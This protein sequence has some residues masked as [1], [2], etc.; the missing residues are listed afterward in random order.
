ETVEIMEFVDPK[1]INPLL[2]YKPYY[3]EP[4]K[5]GGKAY[6]LLRDTLLQTATVGISKVVIKTRQ[7]LAALKP[8]QKALALELMRFPEELINASELDIPERTEPG[9]HELAI[10]KDLVERMT[11]RWDPARYKDDYRSALQKLIQQRV[12]D[13]DK[14]T[15]VSSKHSRQPTGVIDLVEILKNSLAQVDRK[16]AKSA[17]AR[18]IP[19][20]RKAA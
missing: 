6:V 15:Q 17:R 1:E 14:P 16:P 20:G 18:P 8:H 3:I 11:T 19:K 5:A 7:Y 9:R 10:A 13:G 12:R 2:F 4:L